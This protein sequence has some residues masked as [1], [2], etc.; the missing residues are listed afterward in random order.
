ME[1]ML[2]HTIAVIEG[3]LLGEQPRS[4]VDRDLKTRP[5]LLFR[6]VLAKGLRPGTPPRP[7]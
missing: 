5:S 7:P 3:S 1:D 2:G 4:L 6:D